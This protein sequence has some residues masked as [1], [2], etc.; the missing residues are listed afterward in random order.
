MRGLEIAAPAV[1]MSSECGLD[2]VGSVGRAGELW[3]DTFARRCSVS[4]NRASSSCSCCCPVVTV[5][6]FCSIVLDSSSTSPKPNMESR[7]AAKVWAMVDSGRALGGGLIGSS[8]AMFERATAR[9]SAVV[10]DGMQWYVQCLVCRSSDRPPGGTHVACIR[11]RT[12]GAA[13]R[14]G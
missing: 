6:F 11:R 9:W 13:A 10:R 3:R 7:S 12:M 2:S 4:R 1:G 14:W 8:A 5:D